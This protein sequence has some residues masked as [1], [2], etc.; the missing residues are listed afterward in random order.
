MTKRAEAHRAPALALAEA[1]Y[2]RLIG[3]PR[4]RRRRFARQGDLLH[5]HVEAAGRRPALPAPSH[6]LPTPPVRERENATRHAFGWLHDDL[7]RH[8]QGL[9]P[10]HSGRA[11]DRALVGCKPIVKRNWSRSKAGSSRASPRSG[12]HASLRLRPQGGDRRVLHDEAGLAHNGG[13][14]KGGLLLL[15]TWHLD[16]EEF[17]ECAR[18]RRRPRRTHDMNTANWIRI[19]S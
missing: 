7:Q 4:N 16:I 13:K 11:R 2:A 10:S 3:P 12:D 14:R 18:H 17:L 15:E 19:S 9:R 5:Q 6:G 1:A 8:D